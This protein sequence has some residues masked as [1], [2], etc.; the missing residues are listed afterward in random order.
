MPEENDNTNPKTLG[1]KLDELGVPHPVYIA[2]SMA[3]ESLPDDELSVLNNALFMDTF[4][5]TEHAYAWIAEELSWT[6]GGVAA[7]CTVAALKVAIPREVMRR[8]ESGEGELA[9]VGR[10][11]G[12]KGGEP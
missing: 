2:V 3:A 10:E 4:P 7:P 12:R 5:S 11:M 6:V 1:D 9:R 8:V